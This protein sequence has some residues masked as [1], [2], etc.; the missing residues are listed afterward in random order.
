MGRVPEYIDV[1]G[2]KFWTLFDTGARNTYVLK[3]VAEH[4]STSKLPKTFETVLGGSIKKAKTSALL[5]GKSRGTL[6]PL[7]R[8]S[9]TTSAAMKTA[10][11]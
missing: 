7:M 9:W 2:H 6:F 5:E 11:R 3:H 4:L 10:K 8:S 1:K